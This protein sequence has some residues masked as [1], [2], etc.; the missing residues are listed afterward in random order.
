MHTLRTRFRNGIVAEFLPPSRAT[1]KQRVVIIASGA[2]SGPSKNSL[3]EF[4]SK[5]GFWAFHFRYKGSWESSGKFLATP[6]DNDILEIIDELPTGFPDLWNYRKLTYK[7][8]RVKPDQIIILASSFG[9]AAGI[10]A[11][12]D[13][14]VDKVVSFSPL[15]DWTR[16][17]PEEP[18]RRMIKYFAQGF[19]EG[20]RFAPKAW[21]K[22]QSGKFFN[23]IRHVHEMDGTKNLII[24]AKDDRTCPY[25]ITKNFAEDTKTKLVTLKKGGHLSCSLITK[26][27][28]YKLFTAYIK[29]INSRP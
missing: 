25:F 21:I 2:P 22:L 28:F 4:L 13:P 3:I 24:H 7:T 11:S 23:P 27:R 14:R 1:K 26:P 10:L 16:P 29:K 17:G 6:P 5:K 15:I 18:Y 20:Y 8:Y 9:G 19:G 12:R